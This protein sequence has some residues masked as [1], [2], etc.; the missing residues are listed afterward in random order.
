MSASLVSVTLENGGEIGHTR[1]Q[2]DSDTYWSMEVV[3]VPR[4]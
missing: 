1:R 3:R 2:V 4:V